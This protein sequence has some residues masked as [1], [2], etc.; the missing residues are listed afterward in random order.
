MARKLR[1]QFFYNYRSGTVRIEGKIPL[2]YGGEVGTI[3]IPGVKSVSKVSAGLYTVNFDQKYKGMVGWSV[4][5]QNTNT[6]DGTQT[7]ATDGYQ[8]ILVDDEFVDGG[9]G[10]HAAVN[11]YDGYAQLQIL[12]A[13]GTGAATL[14]N[15]MALW[16]SFDLKTSDI[17]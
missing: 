12:Q 4:G 11:S 5:I 8:A 13:D 16:I 1:N 9:E 6:W 15:G 14:C 17:G 2:S 3:D 7:I 10:T